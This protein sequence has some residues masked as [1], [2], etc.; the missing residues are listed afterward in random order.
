MKKITKSSIIVSIILAL[1]VIFTACSALSAENSV[2]KINTSSNGISSVDVK[3]D[4]SEYFNKDVVFELPSGISTGTELSLIVKLNGNSILDAYESADTDLTLSQ[5]ATSDKAQAIR[6]QINYSKQNLLASFDNAN[7]SYT[8]GKNYDTLLGGFEINA[9]ARDFE[10]INSL[11]G[12]LG[13]VIIGDEYEVEETVLVENKVSVYDT[14]IFDSSN[15]DYDGSGIVVAVLDTGLDYTHTAFSMDNFHPSSL[16]LTFDDVSA[17]INDTRASRMQSGLTASDVYISEKVPYG[18]DY[19]DSDSEVFPISSHHG[20]H[21]SGVIAGKDDVITGVAPNA[22]LVE[23]KIFS[24][25][26]A[27]ARAS[28][29]LAAL[30]DCVVLDVDIIN[31]SI[32]TSCGFSRTTDK[33]A[34]SGVYDRIYDCGI[35]MVAA[36]SNSFN[37][38]YG[39]EKNGNLGL[40][41]NPDSATVSSPAT[42]ESTLSVASINGAHTPYLLYNDTIIYFIE[43]T[44]RFSEEKN[45]VNDLLGEGKDSATI[46]YITIPGVGRDADYTGLDVTGKIALVR[47][48]SNTF[49]EKAN[50]AQKKGAKGIIIYNNVSGDIKMTVG[51]ATLAV[52]SISQDDGELLAEQDSGTIQIAKSQSSGPFMSDFSSWGPTPDLHIKPEVTAHGGEI[53]SSVPGQDYDR[54]SGT[55]MATPNMSGVTALLRQYVKQN[56]NDISNNNKEIAATV[57][58]LIMSTADIVRNTNGLPYSVRKQGAGLA[59]LVNAGTTKA[60]ILTYDEAGNAMNKSKIELG[61]DPSKTGEYTLNF[62]IKNFGFSALTY[63]VDTCVMTEGVSET[64]TNHGDTTVTEDGYLLEGAIVKIASV[65]GA[66]SLNGTSVTVNAGGIANVTINI[67]LTEENKKYLDES[68]ANGMFVEGFVTLDS[69]DESVV[70]L[71]VPYLAFY[72]NWLLAPLFDIDYFETDKDALDDSIDLLDKTLPDAFATR[73]VGGINSDYVSYLGSFNYEQKPG[74][75]LISADRK[76]ISISNHIDS[77]NSVQYVWAGL[78]RN[79]AEIYITV[80]DDATGEVVYETVE[81]NIRKSYGDGGTIRPANIDVGF[82]AIDLNLKNN[83]TYTVTLKGALH[84]GDGGLDVNLNNEFSFPVYVDFQ[85]PTL[86]DCEYYTE[87]DRS[88]KKTRLFAKMSIYD[89]HY[90]MAALPGYVTYDATNGFAFENLDRYV[91]QIYS[92]Y[93]TN[94]YLIVELTDYIYQIKNGSYNNS[95]AVVLFDYALNQATYEIPL[96]ADFVDFYFNET[97]V[98]LSPN[99]TY[100]LIPNVYP[101]TEWP[102]LLEFSSAN[103]NVA[104]IVNNEVLALAPGSSVIRASYLVNGVRKTATFTLKVLGQGEEGYRRVDQPVV[105]TF[106]LTGYKIDKVFYF[107][108]SNDRDLGEKAGDVMKFVGSNYNLS[109]YPSESV[110]LQY[111]LVPYFPADTE[112]KFESSNSNIVKVDANGTITAVQEGFGSISVKVYKNGKSTYY[113]KS[114]NVTVK[115]PYENSGPTLTHYFGNGGLVSIPDDL[116]ITEIGSFAFSNYNYIPK[117]EHEIDEYEAPELT[118]QWYLGENT[119]EEIIIPDGVETINSYAFAG[120]TALRKVTLPKSL[121]MIAQGAFLG[122][123]SLTTVN[124]IEN[125]KFFNQQAFANC[126]LTG[127][128]KLTE[129]VALSDYAFANNKKIT[130]VTTSSKTQSI[131]SYAF[132]GNVGLTTVSVGADKIKLGQYAFNGCTSLNNVNINTQVIPTGAFNGCTALTDITIGKDVVVIGEYAFRQT[133]I[134]NFTVAEG[135]AVYKAQDSKPYLLNKDGN[136]ILIVAPATKELIVTDTNIVSIGYGAAAGNE[137]LLTV[138]APSVTKL[139][140]YAFSECSNLSSATFGTLTLIGNY[141]LCKTKID[142]LPSFSAVNKLGNYAFAGTKITEVSIPDG[143]TIGNN[144]FEECSYLATVTIGNDVT[145]GNYAFRFNRNNNF[146]IEFY[147]VTETVDGNP[148]DVQYFYYVYTS[149]LHTLTIGNNA[150]IGSGAFF[151]AAELTEITLGSGAVIGSEAFYNNDKLEIIDLSEVK[152]IDR[153]AFSGDI[154]YEY[155]DQDC[156]IAAIDDT[157]NY[158]YRYYAP[159]LASVDIS[160]V[161]YLGASAFAYNTDLVSVTLGGNLTKLLDDTFLSCN[162]LNS[163]NLDNVTDIGNSVFAENDFTTVDLPKIKTIGDYAFLQNENLTTVTLGGD[164][165]SVGEGAFSYSPVLTAVNGIANVNYIGNYAFAYTALTNVDLTNAISIGNHAFMKENLTDFTV[166]LGNLLEDMGDNPFAMCKLAPLSTVEKESFNNV[167]YEKVVLTYDLTENIR[168]IDGSIYRVVPNGLELITY[169]V[170]NATNSVVAE[171]TVRIG[172]MAF[173]GSDVVTAILPYT[174]VNIGHKAFFNCDKLRTVVFSSYNAPK[175][176]E[177]YDIYY[178]YNED[179]VPGKAELGGL[180]IVDYNMFNVLDFST[181]YYYGANFIDVIGHID[182]KITMIRPVN[183]QNYGSFIFGQYFDVTINGAAA[184]D[185]VTL[186]AIAAIGKLPATVK[187]T[188]KELVLAARSA[189]DKIST[190][191][192]RSLVTNYATL[193][194]AEKRIADL[195]YLDSDTPTEEPKD[196]PIADNNTDLAVIIGGAVGGFVGLVAIIIG[197]LFLVK[198][199]K[200]KKANKEEI[201]ENE[202]TEEIV[203]E[204]QEV[205]EEI[206]EENQEVSVEIV[207]ENVENEVLDEET[208]EVVNESEEIVEE[209]AIDTE[210]T[211]EEVN[212]ETASETE[213]TVEE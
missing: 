75:K 88:E 114:L 95:I 118:K 152:R 3:I 170:T 7:I 137:N 146:K 121:T 41:S 18:F 13:T 36:A 162:S 92:D 145:I 159:A 24:D 70:D 97:T 183:G 144:C 158:I 107:V 26:E 213:E 45:F 109:F 82:S 122:C 167:E 85:A 55:S 166:K 182:N 143:M 28:W 132:S 23:M 197:L 2:G 154:I 15:Y 180:G 139:N 138:S 198:F 119:I 69:N 161:E 131:A 32:G 113:S 190:L 196:E 57:N 27:T 199:L 16:G 17:V 184:A 129:A 76:Y 67:T 165:T 62:S 61:D 29:I 71:S 47:R 33:E 151:G 110:T 25:V 99:Q 44:D 58:R 169:V 181:N 22:Q 173:A 112:I 106:E 111:D 94:S 126:N 4:A 201:V 43:S 187:L 64:K 120:L 202:E 179:N 1:L 35:S 9:K 93:N 104:R 19:A 59:N 34:I 21:V 30:E 149:P 105:N 124:G 103:E 90:S 108:D 83:A 79:A 12:S 72:G 209:T 177:E 14:G 123:T 117:E 68:F 5:F 73:P 39:S 128:L 168:I 84:Y 150:T 141:A 147:T 160:K 203:E 200:K 191:E 37:S 127:E 53:L 156:T 78:L 86:T 208:V 171:G 49:E 206:V 60:Y 140:D 31:M 142:E 52:C 10:K 192:Q 42:Y 98:T 204:N 189:Y 91:T 80:T 54:I 40:T 185:D 81:R 205:S 102:E 207:E 56:F 157:D 65:S 175:L 164:V 163:V 210:E 100:E 135:N 96:P 20:T 178:F 66:G 212:E 46:E 133:A 87:Y 186:A 8:L 115:D 130:K 176:E 174:L 11:V 211:V 188:D 63:D 194:Q 153:S 148:I 101:E 51:D 116:A 134:N 48:G 74:S 155:I 50:T 89:N 172:A 77:V 125:V 6:N 195:E 136:E 193:T 38:T